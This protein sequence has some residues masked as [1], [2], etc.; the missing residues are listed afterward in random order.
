MILSVDLHLR[1]SPRDEHRNLAYVLGFD[2]DAGAE[3]QRHLEPDQCAGGRGQHDQAQCESTNW[4]SFGLDDCLASSLFSFPR[5]GVSCP[6]SLGVEL[7]ANRPALFVF[8]YN[9]E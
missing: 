2:R 8:F 4:N 5:P 6:L 9:P 3:H 7:S 1:S